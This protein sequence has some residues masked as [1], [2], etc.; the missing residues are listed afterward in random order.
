MNSQ[1][2]FKGG[3]C[4]ICQERFKFI[5][6][7]NVK[8]EIIC[9][10]CWSIIKKNSD[11]KKGIDAAVNIANLTQNEFT[12]Y[13]DILEKLERSRNSDEKDEYLYTVIGDIKTS[14]HLRNTLIAYY[15]ATVVWRWEKNEPVNIFED[16]LKKLD[17]LYSSWLVI[18]AI[19]IKASEEEYDLHQA[20]L[21]LEIT[22][23]YLIKIWNIWSKIVQLIGSPN[24][25]ILWNSDIIKKDVQIGFSTDKPTDFNTPESLIS[26]SKRVC[27][28]N[29]FRDQCLS[30]LNK[31]Y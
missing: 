28:E 10:F 15:K 18:Q 23:D 22:L 9:R 13:L 12:K 25:L 29:L 31:L 5:R 1:F 11:S 3:K 4:S 2:R 14:D 8:N 26:E 24:N 16:R 21:S 20:Q 19:Q 27:Q 17:E 30:S 7:V 6:G